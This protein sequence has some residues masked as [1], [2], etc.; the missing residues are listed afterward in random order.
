MGLSYRGFGL[1]GMLPTP[2]EPDSAPSSREKLIT[3]QSSQIIPAISSHLHGLFRLGFLDTQANKL[4]NTLRPSGHGH[5]LGRRLASFL[6]TFSLH[7][8]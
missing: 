1:P 6:F 7:L 3:L 5:K 8:K 2:Q 4:E